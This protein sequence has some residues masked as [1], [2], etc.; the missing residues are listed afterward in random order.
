MICDNAVRYLR[1]SE[2]LQAVPS[3][4]IVFSTLDNLLVVI[5]EALGFTGS[6]SVKANNSVLKKNVVWYLRNMVKC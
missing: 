6:H 4:A 5:S 2:M 3:F 1:N